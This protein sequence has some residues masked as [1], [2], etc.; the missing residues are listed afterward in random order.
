[1][2]YLSS[3][4]TLSR[5]KQ[6]AL[7]LIVATL[8]WTVGLPTFFTTASAYVNVVSF[9]ATA[10]SS[11]PLAS[12]NYGIQWTTATATTLGATF[13]ITFSPGTSDFSFASLSTSTNDIS[14]TTTNS[15]SATYVGMF[16]SCSGLANEF[17]SATTSN[18]AGNRH[19]DFTMCPS[20]T[21]AS[22]VTL[23]VFFT[24]NHVVNPSS[25][26]SYIV[27]VSDSQLNGNLGDTRVAIISQVTVTAA[28]DTALTFTINAVNPGVLI[29]GTTTTATS[30]ATT[31]TLGTTT[32]GI[33]VIAAQDLRVTTNARNGFQVTVIQSGNLTSSNGADIDVFLAN[34]GT[35]TPSSWQAPQTLLTNENTWGHYGLMTNDADLGVG[36]PTFGPDQWVGNFATT[37]RLVFYHATS[38]DGSTQ[39]I[40]MTKVVYALQVSALQEAATDYTNTLTYVCTPTF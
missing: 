16:T 24:N 17:Y 12:T 28:V 10:S 30:T 23:R 8:T 39:N 2:N 27:R 34:N 3:F 36:V 31:I 21:I 22:G 15:G 20:D 11:A 1:M 6:L 33:P 32:P 25:Q 37:T 5:A 35:G 26:T 7:L 4:K 18:I 40:G 38:S 9:S 13:T 19:V 14:A 29:N